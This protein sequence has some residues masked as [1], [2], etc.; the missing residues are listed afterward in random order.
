M[1][2]AVLDFL[3]VAEYVEKK[4]L[5]NSML[6]KKKQTADEMAL[7]FG[8]SMVVVGMKNGS[9]EIY[10]KSVAIQS[11]RMYLYETDGKT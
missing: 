6:S 2:Q 5:S 8:Y 7:K 4:L 1:D 3:R 9:Y 11:K 10:P